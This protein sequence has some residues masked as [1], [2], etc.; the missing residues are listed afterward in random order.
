MRTAISVRG[1]TERHT[2]APTIEPQ[3]ER[4]TAHLPAPGEPL[5][6][7]DIFRDDGSRGATLNRPGLDR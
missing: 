4:L 6:P 3:V 7:E 2:L 5:R 1:S